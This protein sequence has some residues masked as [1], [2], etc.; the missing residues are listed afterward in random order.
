MKLKNFVKYKYKLND[1]WFQAKVLS[2]QQKKSGPNR[3]WINVHVEEDKPISVNWD[4]V[5][6]WNELPFP[7][8][9]VLLTADQEMS[10]EVVMR[11]Q[12]N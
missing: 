12:V 5:Q 7:E 11:K 6:D 4:D 10:Q 9:Y 3:N 1:E 8:G 2:M